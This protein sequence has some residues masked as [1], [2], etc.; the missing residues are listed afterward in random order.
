MKRINESI[1]LWKKLKGE[2][3]DESNNRIKKFN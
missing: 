2:Y 3:R 1:L